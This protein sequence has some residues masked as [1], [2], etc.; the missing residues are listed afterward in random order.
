MKEHQKEWNLESVLKGSKFGLKGEMNFNSFPENL[1]GIE[2]IWR[3][4][5]VLPDEW[6]EVCWDVKTGK[7]KNLL[8]K[9]DLCI[10]PHIVVEGKPAYLG[11]E[12]YRAT[13]GDKVIIDKTL[14]VWAT[15]LTWEKPIPKLGFEGRELKNT[16]YIWYR[17]GLS[18]PWEYVSIL[19][20]GASNK[21]THLTYLENYGHLKSVGANRF[22]SWEI[23]TK[24]IHKH[25]Y[26]DVVCFRISG[27]KALDV[28]DYFRNKGDPNI[29]W[30]DA[31][32]GRIELTV[33]LN[34]KYKPNA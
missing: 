5:E 14:D 33:R 24:G 15:P 10:I 32:V 3:R 26:S 4:V 2:L 12:L 28:V 25:D 30:R 34:V 20:K 11:D 16:D 18:S 6:F 22:Y 1:K 8:F 19:E 23:P 29:I 17:D 9:Y 13:T 21:G 7:A 31:A 27:I